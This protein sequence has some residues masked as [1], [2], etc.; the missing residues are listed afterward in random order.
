MSE[1]FGDDDSDLENRSPNAQTNGPK[2]ISPEKSKNS[3][4]VPEERQSKRPRQLSESSSSSDSLSEEETE[5]TPSE[6]DR[7]RSDLEKK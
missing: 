6:S 4:V 3:P 5:R 7:N 1:L 2:K